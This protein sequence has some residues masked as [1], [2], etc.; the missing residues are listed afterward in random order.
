MEKITLAGAWQFRQVGTEE[1]LPATVPGGVHTD[2]MAL[3]RIP[4]PFV[5]DNEKKVAWVAKTDWEY[6]HTFEVSPA[7]LGNEQVWLV[8]DGLDTLAVLVLNGTALGETSN[9]FRQYHWDVK[10]LL[11]A[12]GNELTIRFNSVVEYG[13]QKEALRPLAGVSQAITGGPYVRKAPCHFGWDWGPQLPPIGIWKDIRLEAF[14]IARL[15]EVHL[16]Q[17]HA[18]GMLLVCL[19]P[20]L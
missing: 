2:L 17:A 20:C 18:D 6:T 1:W 13:A 7:M 15:E 11:R 10:P 16:R 5:G 19:V 8:C 4:D 9:M 12:E 14:N 3:N